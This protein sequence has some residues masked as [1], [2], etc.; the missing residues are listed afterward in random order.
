MNIIPFSDQAIIEA[1]AILKNGGVIAH[2]T[3]TCYGLAC[4]LSN[5]DAV[6]KLF[7]IKQRPEHQPVSGLFESVDQA[8][9]YVE[10]NERAEELAAQY[11]PGPLTIILPMK[12]EAPKQLHAIAGR[13]KA[14]GREQ[15]SMLL[16][17]DSLLT[18]TLG[19][20]ISSSPIA[21]S[22]VEA[23]ASPL[24]TTSANVHGQPNPYSAEDIANQFAEQLM[25][26]DLILDSGTLPKNPPSTVINLTGGTEQEV[27]A[28]DT[29]L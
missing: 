23:F 24:S 6:K 25:Q 12:D 10:W 21:Q 13:Q 26:P 14:E 3:E 15:E 16:S 20:R 19:I 28:G 9:Q 2:A 5:I 22:L 1:I 4:D 29:K 18:T 7:A 11:L 8:K 27:R 17:D